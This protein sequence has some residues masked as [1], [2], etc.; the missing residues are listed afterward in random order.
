MTLLQDLRYAVRTAWRDRAFS[1]IAVST[2]ALGI[3]ANT[4]LFTIVNAILLAPLP[5]RQPEQL[6]RVTAD[7]T[8]Q[9]VKDAGLSVPEL[10]DLRQA[11]VFDEVGGVWAISANLTETDE[12]ERVETALV[13]ATYFKMLGVGAQYGRV[14][15]EGDRQPGIAEVTVISDGLWKRRFGADP[16]VLGK[17]IR[18]DNDMYSI[19]GVAPAGFRHPGRGTATEVELWAP[20]GWVASPFS[21]EPIRR[22][23][24]LQGALGRLKP[25]VTVAAAQERIDALAGRLRREYP[26][27]YPDGAGW[28]LRVIPLHDDLV[29]NVRPALLTLVAAVGF[30]LLIA[31]ANV[32]NLLLARSSARQ[33]EIAV[34]R[35]LGASRARLV[36]QLLT[37]S[38]LLA[39]AGGLFGLLVAVWGVDGLVRLGPSSLPR[40]HDVGVDWTVLAFTAALSIATGI[41]FGLAPAI[42]GSH[43]ELQQVIREAGRSATATGRTTRLRS[44]LVVGEFALALVLLVGAALL[45]QSFWRLQRVDL[46]FNPASVLT[47]RLW[48]P[49]PNLPETG[50]YFTHDARVSFYTRVLDRIAALPGVEAAGGVTSLPLS[51]ATGRTTFT[52]EGRPAAA[53]GEVLSSEAS[54]VTPGYFR[55]L[56]IDLVR[57]RLFDAHDDVK[58]P[59]AAVV[60]ESFARQFFPGDDALGKRLAPGTRGRAGAGPLATPSTRLSI[61]GIVRDVKNGRLDAGDAPLLYRSVLQTSNLNLTLVVRA[62][63]D[64]AALTESLRR[65]VRE[66]DPNEPLFGVRT[67]DEVV[68]AALAERR[69]TM[70]LLALFA[71]TALALSAIGI[72]G[73]MAYFVT[74]RTHEIGVRMALGASARDVLAMVLGQGARLAA[75]G[76]VA[77]VAGALVVTRAIATLLFGVG[78]RDPWTLIA[79]SAALTAV[80]LLAC[81][82]PARRATRVDPIRAL[83]YE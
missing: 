69:F 53:A 25:G 54:F 9:A 26:S 67:M 2:L 56:G 15:D 37:E 12:P 74:Q 46:G 40:L 7:F 51:G 34:R 76:V 18:I 29:G 77:G 20:A 42:Q 44:T 48:L 11:D 83:R 79:L 43:A 62:R 19:I 16:G 70:L 32:A 59:L 60:S 28:T 21:P 4:A 66:V 65:E 57:G 39:A 6:V 73:V 47:A 23:Y 10:F 31:C 17:R 52:I 61:V 8:R 58:A 14:F 64:P 50:P 55:A 41:L 5:F 82:L 22:A 1:L 30:V 33:R 27:D 49:Q 72:Y 75:A 24:L 36:R 71:V 81:Y 13:D 45:V 68:G 80:A 38:V 63:H 78:P 3:G 35:A